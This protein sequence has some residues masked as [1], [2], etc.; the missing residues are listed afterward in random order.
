MR[1]VIVGNLLLRRGEGGLLLLL[2]LLWVIAVG[3]LGWVAV[4][5]VG[6]GVVWG[7]W[8]LL[9]V[10]R[11]P[12]SAFAL[13][14]IGGRDKPEVGMD[15]NCRNNV[16]WDG[17]G[18]CTPVAMES[19]VVVVGRS[20]SYSLAV[21]KTVAEVAGIVRSLRCM[22]VVLGWLAGEGESPEIRRNSRL[23]PCWI[24]YCRGIIVICR[25]SKINKRW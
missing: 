20:L 5:L 24:L 4:G 10:V 6:V 22:E 21:A 14:G 2:L 12:M 8:L 19:R 23:L 7:V 17:D 13:R 11:R 18:Y 15:A 16:G 3:L 1:V 25:L 9:L